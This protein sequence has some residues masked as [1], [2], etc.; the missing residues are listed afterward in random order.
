MEMVGSIGKQF[1]DRKGK[2]MLIILYEF[3][4]KFPGY[5]F[6][7]KTLR[8]KIHESAEFNSLASRKWRMSGGLTLLMIVVYFGFILLIAFDKPFLAKPL[9]KNLTIGLPIGI[10]I[11]IFAWL[12]TGIYTYWANRYYDRDVEQLKGKKI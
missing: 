6:I 12:L 4:N 2:V 10:G 3:A 5:S 8:M 9:G 11:L 1:P 7:G